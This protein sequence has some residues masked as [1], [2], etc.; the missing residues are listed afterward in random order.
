VILCVATT[1]S[2]DRL[3]AVDRLVL[4][5]IHR[6]ELVVVVAGGKGLNVARTA[7]ALGADVRAVAPL[8]G[9]A[10]RWI[11]AELDREGVAVDVVAVPAETRSCVS[12]A[13]PDGLTE[14]YEHAPPL[15]DEGWHRLEDA[16]TARLPDVD[17]L[18]LSG[19]LPVGA[20][21]DGH[22]RLIAAAHAAGVHV[23]VDT[24]GEPL[25]HALA[26][27]PELVKVN[28][29][30]AAAAV[31]ALAGDGRPLG[32]ALRALTGGAAVVTHGAD[33]LELCGADGQGARVRPPAL[34]RYPVGSGDA[35]LAGIVCA[36]D[37]GAD[38][39]EA[40]A[41]GVGAAAANAELPGAGRLD[42]ERARALAARV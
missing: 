1:P 16:V 11:A 23:A 41:L 10:G 39:R 36:L 22:A 12:V 42:P 37:A 30:E 26:A 21:Q 17:W 28:A 7:A 18:T 5:T 8:G 35:C 33:G 13:A 31:A 19:S 24:H 25:D 20:P 40:V 38:W 2:I 9:H 27:R 32:A 15:G 14:F 4:G 34:G 29:G 3:F 6:P